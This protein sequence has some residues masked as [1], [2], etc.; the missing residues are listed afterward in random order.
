MNANSVN[1]LWGVTTHYTFI[2]REMPQP[3]SRRSINNRVINI[4]MEMW[5]IKIVFDSYYGK[6][7]FLISLISRKWG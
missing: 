7:C 3:F 5:M 2:L 4:I 1:F 6:G